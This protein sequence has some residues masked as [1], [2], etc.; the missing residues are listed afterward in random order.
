[1]P[2][3][4][5]VFLSLLL[6]VAAM[7]AVPGVA[8]SARADEPFRGVWVTRWDFR[9]P[10][11]VRRVIAECASVQATDVIW[12]ARGQADAFYRSELEPWGREL[13][14]DLPPGA[15]DPGFDPLALAVKEAHARGMKLHA[16][17]NV[18]PLWKGPVPPTDPRHL[19]NSR[20]QWRLHDAAGR[21]Q[22]LNDHY[23]IV[24]PVLEEVQDY[25]VAVFGDIVSRYEIDGLH[26]DYIRFVSEKMD[27]STLYPAD[28]ASLEAFKSATGHDTPAS[29]DEIAAFQDWKR[30]RITDLVRRIR[31]DA[32]DRRPGCV[33]TAAVWRRPDLGL[34]QYLQDGPAW[35]SDGLLDRAF[36]MIYTAKPE[37]FSSDLAAWI[38][39]ASGRPITPGL[40]VYL[41]VPGQTADQAETARAMGTDGFALFSYES[42][43]ESV[44][45]EQS[46]T[47]EMI[48]T[49]AGR[50]AAFRDWLLRQPVLSPHES[51][52]PS[53]SPSEPPK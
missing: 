16:W 40:A 43:F 50:L 34:N 20:P 45:P 42:F 49:R 14:R 39:A 9:T 22:P 4:R 27:A 31:R 7:A 46:K 5:P 25:L 36:P 35:L 10:D 48:A 33:L 21:P 29:P 24:N 3:F 30:A 41:H 26:L 23:V 2:L 28:P 15:T 1:M 13:F 11:D 12:Q 8:P 53:S 6:I 51:S 18:M 38:E 32:V 52:P 44:N 19:L 37:Q 47:P 17:V